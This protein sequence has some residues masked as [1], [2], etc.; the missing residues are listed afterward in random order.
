MILLRSFFI[1]VLLMPLLSNATVVQGYG[2]KSCQEFLTTQQHLQTDNI[3]SVVDELRY[4]SWLMGFVSGINLATDDDVLRGIDTDAAMRR[5]IV[6][7]QKNSQL[8]MMQATMKYIQ[9][10]QSIPHSSN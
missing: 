3:D 9:E 8:T 1:V 5:I 4:R 7:C 10:L 2:V 6:H